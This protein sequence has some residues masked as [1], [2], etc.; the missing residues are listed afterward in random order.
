MVKEVPKELDPE[1]DSGGALQGLSPQ[2]APTTLTQAPLRSVVNAIQ[3]GIT[4]AV[5]HEAGV[6][7]QV[8]PNCTAHPNTPRFNLNPELIP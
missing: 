5:D 4:L 3:T 1:A 2:A 7:E 8:P 6:R